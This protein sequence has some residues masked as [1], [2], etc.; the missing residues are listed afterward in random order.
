MPKALLFVCVN[1]DG[2]GDFSHYKGIYLALRANPKIRDYDFVHFIRP[3]G[4]LS[5]EI[6]QTWLKEQKEENYYIRRDYNNSND[7]EKVIDGKKFESELEKEFLT[8][9]KVFII[10]YEMQD[11]SRLCE[12]YPKKIIKFIGEH[13]RCNVFGNN[14]NIISRSLGLSKD[15]YGLKLVKKNRV[16]PQEATVQFEKSNQ[17]WTQALL[18]YTQSENFSQFHAKNLLIPAYFNHVQQFIRFLMVLAG[19]EKLAA[20]P[21]EFAIYFSSSPRYLSMTKSFDKTFS[22]EFD[23][24]SDDFCSH[25]KDVGKIEIIGSESASPHILILNNKLKKTIRIFYGFK[26][27]NSDYGLLYRQAK[28]AG[29][30]GDNTLET[31]IS[32]QV[33]PYYFSTNASNKQAT[34]RALIEIIKENSFEFTEEVKNDFIQFFALLSRLYAGFSIPEDSLI[35]C[36]KIDF[37]SMMNA[38]PSIAD[39]L[40]KKHNFYDRLEDIFFEQIELKTEQLSS[41]RQNVSNSLLQNNCLNRV[42]GYLNHARNYFFSTNNARQVQSSNNGS[43][44][45]TTRPSK[46]QENKR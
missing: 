9:E 18:K 10:S 28:I 21:Q 31:A 46:T 2:T 37:P 7:S 36:R 41:A 45:K 26:L 38:W 34:L 43:N 11:F 23:Q 29:V 39:H 33:L 44:H 24:V 13:E 40:I 6:I 17:E 22:S 20:I 8:A 30:S 27:N 15:C 19:N 12:K 1:S 32:A 16:Q 35:V 25:V 42:R 4:S 5:N 14:R 3:A